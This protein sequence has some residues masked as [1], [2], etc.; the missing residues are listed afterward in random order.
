MKIDAKLLHILSDVFIDIAKAFF[1][2]AIVAPAL[3]S[4]SLW[5]SVSALTKN[6][7]LGTVFLLIAWQL[8]KF[9]ERI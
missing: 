3:S 1:I 4:V 7:L 9:K 5:E 2:A 6:Y 8:A